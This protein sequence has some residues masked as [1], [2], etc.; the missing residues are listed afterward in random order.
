MN[1]GNT[2]NG[3]IKLIMKQRHPVCCQCTQ[4]KRCSC[5]NKKP[6]TTNPCFMPVYWKIIIHLDIIGA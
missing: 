5:R 1:F 6:C 2:Y 4:R 3:S